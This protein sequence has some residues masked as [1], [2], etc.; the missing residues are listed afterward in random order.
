MADPKV[1]SDWLHKAEEDFQFA[2]VCLRDLEET[3]FSPI[4]FHFQQSAEKY[5]K[6]YIITNDLP[7]EK[8]HDLLVLLDIC[9]TKEPSFSEL[10][11]DCEFLTDFYIE[12]RY[13][14]H[15]P[16]DIE[17]DEAERARDACQRIRELVKQ[18]IP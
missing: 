2:S 7:F 11:E 17:R 3:F 14:V 15:W 18:M 13:P 16:S 5:L 8:I 10:R 4:C 12:T 1:V 6:S 9:K